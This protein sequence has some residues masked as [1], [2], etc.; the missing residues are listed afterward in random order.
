LHF[1]LGRNPLGK[2]FVTGI[3]SNPVRNPHYRPYVIRRQSPP[4]LL[5]KGPTLDPVFIE[6]G[7]RPR[8]NSPPPAMKSYVD[9]TSTHWCNEPDIEVQGHLIGLLAWADISRTATT[10][11][12][13][14]Q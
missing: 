11:T 6:K 2:V 1:I 13:R 14:E 10:A 3:G 12:N 4:G 5:V 8:Y 9:V 7:I